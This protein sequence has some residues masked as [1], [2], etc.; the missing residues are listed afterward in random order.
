[1]NTFQ[2]FS[3]IKRHALL[4]EMEKGIFDVVVFGGGI[5]GAGIALDAASRGLCVA[6]IEQNDFASGT[7]SRSTKLVHGGLRYL[8]K[9]QFRFVAHL[10]KERKILHDNATHNVI[11][12]PVFLPISKGGQLKKGL[13]FLGL[14][15]YDYLAGVKKEYRTRWIT[16]EQLIK[17]YPLI[18]PQG[19][20]GA[21]L[22]YEYK[23][24]DGRLVIETLKKA[25]DLGARALNFC[26]LF[27]LNKRQDKIVEA[28]VLDLIS[29]REFL[30][31]GSFFINA[32]G[33]WSGDFLKQFDTPMPKLLYPTKGIHVVISKERF[34]I[35]EAFY[36]DTHD[37]RMIFAIPKYE[38]VYVGTTDT[39]YSGDLRN[40]QVDTTAID[41]LLLAVNLKFSG[42]HLTKTD[43]ISCW[44]GI[45]P[46][47]QDPGKKPDEISRKEELFISPSGLITITGGKLTGFRLMA[48][49]VVDRIMKQRPTPFIKCKTE[50]IRASG[51]DWLIPPDINKLVE[52]ADHQFDLAKQTG[53]NPE[54]FKK[55]FY[56]YG[57]NMEILT[58]KAY[59]WMKQEE[60]PE[61]LW[62][63]V[64][65][66][67]AVTHE[68]TATLSGFFIYRSEM[69]LF[70]PE[71]VQ[72]QLE[73]VAQCMAEL[74]SW[75][76]NEKANQI[77][78]FK[79]NWEEYQ[80]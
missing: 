56:R 3:A 42:L 21:F 78:Q 69:V 28:R 80:P 11:P 8:E 67:Y 72:H 71:K 24:N 4:E 66:W 55:L 70:E 36:F 32:T 18:N 22:Y 17:K 29:S 37:H 12:T 60:N 64:E 40:P 20:K 46:L 35:N 34:P 73:W 41:Y 14:L 65:I 15:V 68:M 16:K 39:P 62:T 63:K 51:S 49:Q 53:I 33:P 57:T 38:H 31:K 30:I 52:L 59:E 74:L 47:I 76:L 1:M 9:L 50:T 61:M 5:T 77:A 13:S 19:L 27:E 79:K 26:E 7:S 58:E 2:N 45:R 44:A 23:T 48:K 10:G 6:L 54:T 75:T 43:V 25:S